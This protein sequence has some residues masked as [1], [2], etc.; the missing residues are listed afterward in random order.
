MFRGK[1]LSLQ[2]VYLHIK[3]EQKKSEQKK[4]KKKEEGKQ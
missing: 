4:N 1:H 3:R 2:N